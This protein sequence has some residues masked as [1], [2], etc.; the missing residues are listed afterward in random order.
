M[1]DASVVLVTGAA[2]RIGACIATTFHRNGFKVIVHYNQSIEDAQSLCDELN[3]TRAD[4]AI[5][6]GA[7]LTD[8]I[9]VDRLAVQSLDCFNRLDV[10][11][12][13]ASSYYPTLFGES[14][15]Q[16]WDE[17]IDSNLRAA[18]F[19]SQSLSEEIR[20]R[21]GAI[22]NLVDTHAD[23]PLSRHPIYSIA[24]AGMKAM[25][26][27]LAVELAP[28]VRVNGVSPGAILWP[29]HLEN[30]EDPKVLQIRKKVLESIPLGTLG[31]P[32]NIADTV[33]FLARKALY[34][35]GQVIKVDGGRSLN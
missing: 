35:N 9:A 15:Q 25:T 18:Y 1:S 29:S 28:E 31:K 20:K 19:L 10:L 8:P 12:N 34:V 16:Q 5:A 6:L 32:E 24:K 7:D 4:S 2:R 21:R 33:Y 27:S 17:L 30:D 22:V 11:V 26:K 23:R 14:T 3:T 13:N